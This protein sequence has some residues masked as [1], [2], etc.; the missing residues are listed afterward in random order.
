MAE[1][2]GTVS[3]GAFRVAGPGTSRPDD[4]VTGE[5]RR[6]PHGAIRPDLVRFDW[7]PRSLQD[8]SKTASF[9][10]LCYEATTNGDTSRGMS[11]A[12]VDERLPRSLSEALNQYNA[13]TPGQR[14]LVREPNRPRRYCP[15]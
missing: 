1:T 9:R 14:S 6:C 8:N 3:F 4:V 5:A 11:D 7:T 12:E 15:K 2:A 10:G 13:V